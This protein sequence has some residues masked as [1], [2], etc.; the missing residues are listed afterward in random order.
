M[1]SFLKWSH[2]IHLSKFLSRTLGLHKHRK[3]TCKNPVKFT[4]ESDRNIKHARS[5]TLKINAYNTLCCFVYMELASYMRQRHSWPAAW[6][7]HPVIL[8]RYSPAK[9]AEF[10][11]ILNNLTVMYQFVPYTQA[12]TLRGRKDTQSPRCFFIGGRRSPPSPPR[13]GVTD[14]PYWYCL[15]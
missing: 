11:G 3:K 8:S 14:V 6:W 10:N 12:K 15:S 7:V 1:T 13:I 2:F 9:M 5:E 4:T